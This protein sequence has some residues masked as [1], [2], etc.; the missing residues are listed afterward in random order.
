[1][2]SWLSRDGAT[3][4]RTACISVPVL[5]LQLVLR[6]HPDWRGDPLVVVESDLPQSEVLWANEVAVRHRVGRG[7]R[8]N[9]AQAVVSRLRA[10]VVPADDITAAIDELL[11]VLA[12]LSPRVEPSRECPGIFWA[13]PNGLERLYSCLQEWARAV[14]LAVAARGFTCSVV[15]GFRRY[16]VFALARSRAGT[17]VLGDPGEE[18]RVARQVDLVALDFPPRLISQMAVLGVRT[19]GGFLRLSAADVRV[20]YG[21]EVHRL[22][23]L[24]SGTTW[25]PL[26][27]ERPFERWR[28]EI[29]VDPPASDSMSLLFLIERVLHRAVEELSARSEAITALDVRLTLEHAPAQH[30]RIETAAPT[31]DITQILE[32]VQLRLSTLTLPAPVEKLAVEVDS[33]RVHPEQGEL[34]ADRPRRDLDAAKR[35]LAR[36]CAAF[37][38]DSVV[39]ARLFARHLPEARFGWERAGDVR[40]PLPRLV[41]GPPPLVRRIHPPVPLPPIPAHEPEAWLKTHGTVVQMH[42]PYRLSGGWWHKR[43]ERDYF[44]V[45]TQ[46]GEILWLFYD[47]PRRRWFLQGVVD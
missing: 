17:S 46:T 35:A 25:E 26:A 5:P 14:Q 10:A 27:P 9:Q 22:H 34:I 2:T 19:L 24:A 38:A 4:Q 8:F 45:E 42:G 32:L 44:Y 28:V 13:D 29:D 16:G 20:R 7:M 11:G 23:Q 39:R 47:R 40:L 36:I 15:V 31:L 3:T 33:V 37:G 43:V 41:P 30:E 21:T 18:E 6:Q 1:M 12:A